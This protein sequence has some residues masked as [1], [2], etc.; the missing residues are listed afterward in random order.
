MNLFSGVILAGVILAIV[1][2]GVWWKKANLLE[3]LVLGVA[4]WFCAWIVAS[5]GLFVL[6]EFRLFRAACATVGL[7]LV[8]GVAAVL[9]RHKRDAVPWRSLVQISWDIKPYWIPLAVCACGAVLVAVKH[10]MYGM[11]QDEGV[12]QT[13]AI[14]LMNGVTDRQQDFAEYHLLS[15]EQ[16]TEF[17]WNVKGY[18]VGYD[19]G[20][21]IYSPTVYD[22]IKLDIYPPTVYDMDVSPV[23][24]IFHGIPTFASLLAMWGM[25]FGMSAMQGVQTVFYFLLIFLIYFICQN[26]HLRR[27]ACA[28]ACVTAAASPIVLWTVKSAL[29]EPFLGVL[30]ALFLYF[31]TSQEHPERQW[32]S[33]L[34]IAVFG[35]Y[36]VSIYTVLPVFLVVYGGMYWL[37]RRRSFAILMPVTVVGYLISFFAMCAAQPFYT[38]NNYSPLFGLGITQK[39][40]PV[41]V[42]TVCAVALAACAGY[43]WLVHRCVHRKYAEMSVEH[44][45]L[46]IKNSRLG[47]ILVELLLVPLVGY[48]IVKFFTND[49]VFHMAQ[50]SAL[51]G[52]LCNTGIFAMAAAWIFGV[53]RP[54]FYLE[55]PAYLVVL[56]MFAYCVLFYSAFLRYTV[57]NYYYY[58]RYLTPFLPI[59]AV[60]AAMTLDRLRTRVMLPLTVAGLVVVAPFDRFLAVS[61]DDTWM[62]W[63]IME[64]L[65]DEITEDDCVIVESA[66]MKPLYLTLRAMTGADAYPVLGG[67]VEA[68]AESLEDR[69]KNVYYIGTLPESETNNFELRYRNTL[70]QSEDYCDVTGKIIPMSLQY[71]SVELPVKMYRYLSPIL[72]YPAEECWSE[73]YQGVGALEKDFCWTNSPLVDVS[74]YLEEMNYTLAIEMG[75]G[76]PLDAIGMKTYPVEVKINGKSLGTMFVDAD[77]NGKALSLAV[78]KELVSDGKNTITLECPLWEASLVAEG[79]ARLMGFPLKSLEFTPD[80]ATQEGEEQI[81]YETDYSNSVLQ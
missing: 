25:L 69:Y 15:P 12:Y 52:F 30:F 32:L 18:L 59:A 5:M 21:D 62:E 65:A 74:C 45:Q 16:Q 77:N 80:S 79:D 11:G 78:P 56:V 9:V 47:I 42:P 7:L 17:E 55:R 75:C 44:Y 31:L 35:C 57:E 70:M 64:E 6:D 76:I 63:D 33:I 1:T 2:V 37:T 14:N 4:Y 48:I 43:I 54:R 68:Q 49:D 58:G 51:Y 50:F 60:F 27:T 28:L 36:H 3:T 22:N 53:I 71:H 34:P 8:V 24:G 66:F 81:E 41:I 26:L 20:S 29:T 72:E 23:S 38:M 10:G 39:D 46:R 13:L 61:K 67:D 40:L 73:Q 19:I